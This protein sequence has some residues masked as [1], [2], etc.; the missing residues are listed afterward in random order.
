MSKIF[1][2]MFYSI[3]YGYR[4]SA[5]KLEEAIKEN[6]KYTVQTQYQNLI[7]DSKGKHYFQNG[8]FVPDN[9]YIIGTMND[10]DRSVESM[11]FAMRRRFTFIEITPEEAKGILYSNLTP[12]LAGVAVEKMDAINEIISKE[13]GPEYQIG[14][15]Y[16]LDLK[17]ETDFKNL[18]KQRIE[19]LIKEY[20]RGED[21][22]ENKTLFDKL[23]KR[24][25]DPTS[26]F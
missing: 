6:S 3:E 23:Q 16:F 7:K 26:E 2:E 24:W 10:I 12:D 17:D 4:V 25:N 9:V 15:A 13:I 14:P 5:D 22:D 11:D 20:R 19:P 18:W 21:K 8:F 1:G